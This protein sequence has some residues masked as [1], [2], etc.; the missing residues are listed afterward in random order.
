MFN[1]LLFAQDPTTSQV[2]E[3]LAAD[4]Q[5]L[6][7]QKSLT[8]FPNHYELSVLLNTHSPDLIFME[9]SELTTATGMVS[10]IRSIDPQIGIV[11]FG[12]GWEN[13]KGS[14]SEMTG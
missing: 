8:K 3:H 5:L 4:A 7:I 1:A 12:A 13:Q 2:I 11:G 10:L 6:T 14:P 9:L